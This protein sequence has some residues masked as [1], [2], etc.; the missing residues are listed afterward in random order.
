VSTA[1]LGRSDSLRFNF[2]HI[3]GDVEQVTIG[4]AATQSRLMY[5]PV[6]DLL[7][8]SRNGLRMYPVNTVKCSQQDRQDAGPA[9]WMELVSDFAM[10]MHMTI[11]GNI[12]MFGVQSPICCGDNLEYDGN[13]YHIESVSH[14]WSIYGGNRDFRTSLQV[15]NGV[16]ADP[17]YSTA[18]K[19]FQDEV[20]FI[21]SDDADLIDQDPGLTAVDFSLKGTSV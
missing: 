17:Q 11:S 18:D 3:Y 1:D 20:L 21:G 6:G 7:D 10:S 2:V 15:T 9:T 19:T 16:K 4:T 8:V 13:V 14:T 12:S 5:P